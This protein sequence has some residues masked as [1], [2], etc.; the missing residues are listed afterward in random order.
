MNQGVDF[1]IQIQNMS[2]SYVKGSDLLKDINLNIPDGVYLSILG[3]NGSCKSTLIKLILGLLKPNYGSININTNKISYVPQRLDNFNGQF[4]ITVKEILASHCKAIKL[5]DS[6]AVSNVLEK[7]NMIDFKNN[8]IGNLSGGQQQR[9]FIARAL[10]GN[11]DLIIL[12]EP[13]T[14]VDEKSQNEIYPLLQDLNK[15]HGKTIISVE[16]N[17]KIALQYSTHILQLNNGK[18]K[19]YTKDEFIK[20]LQCENSISN[21]V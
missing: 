18:I 10:L 7:V 21:I 14:G 4:P 2:F 5:K 20:Y 15:K 6:N 8:L 3:E 13:S 17:T 19:L 1:L 11:P 16:H 12:D 9:I